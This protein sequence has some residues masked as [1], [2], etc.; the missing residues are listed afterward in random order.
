M[1]K[2]T[3]VWAIVGF[4]MSF[5][6]PLLGLIFSIIGYNQIKRN[7]E[8]GN[9]LATAGIIISSIFLLIGILWIIGI[10]VAIA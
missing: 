2:T 1:E 5:I 9:G 3:N 4:I 7:G 6:A 10:M 8:K